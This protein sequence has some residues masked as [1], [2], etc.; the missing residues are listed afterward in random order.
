MPADYLLPPLYEYLLKALKISLIIL[1][2][3]SFILSVVITYKSPTSGFFLLPSRAWEMLVGGLLFIYPFKLSNTVA[4]IFEWLGLSAILLGITLLS[5]HNFWPGY[6]AIIPVIGSLLILAANRT[7]SIIISNPPAQ[8]VGKTSYSIYLWH[9]PVVVLLNYFNIQKNIMFIL[10]GLMC[11]LIL[12][13][14]SFY[15]IESKTHYIKYA[16]S[17][18]KLFKNR[19][20]LFSSAVVLTIGILGSFI[21]L[22]EGVPNRTSFYKNFSEIKN[23]RSYECNVYPGSDLKSPLCVYGNS[24][25]ISAIVLGD[26]HSNSVITAVEASMK[27]FSGGVLFMGADG[28]FSLIDISNSYFSKCNEYNLWVKEKILKDKTLHNL[29]IILVNNMTGIF[30]GSKN[31]FSLINGIKLKQGS[32]NHIKTFT[33]EYKNEVC[34]LRKTNP[35]YIVQPTAKMPVN[36][37]DYLLKKE[38]FNIGDDNLNIPIDVYNTRHSKTIELLKDIRNDCDI[39]LLDPAPYLCTKNSCF[40]TKDKQAIYYDKGHLSEYGNKLLVPMFEKIW[41][42]NLLD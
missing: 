7:D 2:I 8:W 25:K 38:L 14:L 1:T 11:T 23:P 15:F 35:I 28:C 21:Y 37:S 9:W 17:S 31:S 29:P 3:V 27:E 16:P 20:F 5:A 4:K 10:I 40:G 12:S 42:D 36:V 18:G 34:E 19:L 22:T 32:K 13:S 39:T 24:N 26:S 33:E 30:N 41:T 6:L